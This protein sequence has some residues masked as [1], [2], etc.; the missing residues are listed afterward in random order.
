M[1]KNIKSYKRNEKGNLEITSIVKN[2]ENNEIKAIQE[3]S[4][5]EERKLLIEIKKTM[6]E[7]IS[8][9]G[10]KCI[11]NNIAAQNTIN[12]LC[13]LAMSVINKSEIIGALSALTLLKSMSDFLKEYKEIKQIEK[14]I[15]YINNETAFNKF[16]ENMGL[17]KLQID[18]PTTSKK[19]K[20][21]CINDENLNC[22][23]INK[24]SKKELEN[25][26]E[27][28]NKLL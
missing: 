18:N 17:I 7:E 5:E 2:T 24:F 23:S 27:T 25:I 22:I 3:Y 4:K 26:K 19:I 21:L 16:N 14:F 12:S 13:M 8:N 28:T 20:K 1:K 9:Y 15:Y 11:E 6:E 10:S